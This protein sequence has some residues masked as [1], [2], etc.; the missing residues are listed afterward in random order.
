MTLSEL[1][2][3]RPVLA[4][5]H[6]TATPGQECPPMTEI[7]APRTGIPLHTKILLGLAWNPHHT[8][9]RSVTVVP[10]H[11]VTQ[12]RQHVQTI[13]LPVTLAFSVLGVKN[14]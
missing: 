12:Q 14:Q 10:T 5:L 13:R 2:I 6:P 1:S 3:R 11:Q 7:K 4:I 8:P 9:D